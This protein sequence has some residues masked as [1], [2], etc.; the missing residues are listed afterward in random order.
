MKLLPSV[1]LTDTQKQVLCKIVASPT[2]KVAATEISGTPNL[3]AAR[4]MLTKLGVIHFANNQSV[5]TQ[6]GTQMM[7]D[8]ALIDDNNQLTQDGEKFAYDSEQQN[9]EPSTQNTEPF[10]NDNKFAMIKSLLKG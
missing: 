4:D 10:E 9:T 2:P 1:Q 3:V 8:E 7:K 5:L 6:K